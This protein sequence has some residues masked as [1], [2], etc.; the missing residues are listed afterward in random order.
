MKGVGGIPE[1]LAQA[2]ISFPDS[3]SAGYR[4]ELREDRTEVISNCVRK[5]WRGID[6]ERKC[7]RSAI[8]SRRPLGH[9]LF[10]EKGLLCKFRTE[11]VYFINCRLDKRAE[12]PN[13]CIADPVREVR[14]AKQR[15]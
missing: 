15:K 1:L 6:D 10:A 5:N 7:T 4:I 14:N 13:A 11:L 12:V 8:D 3:K 9:P 2:R